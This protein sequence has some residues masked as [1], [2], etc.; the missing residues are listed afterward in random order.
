MLRIVAIAETNNGDNHPDCFTNGPNISNELAVINFL[1]TND[2]TLECQYAPIRFI[3]YDCGDNVLSSVT[4]DTLF[5]SRNIYDFSWGAQFPNWTNI[6][7]TAD[8]PTLF[9]AQ[10]VDCFVGDE[11]KIPFR[12][13]DF[14]NGGI[15][16]VCADSID[17]RGDV[18]LNEIPYEVA[19][20]VLFS[21]YFVY[22]LSA[23]HGNVDGQIAATDANADGIVL[24]VADLVYLIR[25]VIGDANP[26][27]KTVVPI[28]A[29]YVQLGN[30]V[31]SV[32][33]NVEMG[34]AFVVLEGNVAPELKAMNMEMSYNYDGSNTRVLVYSLEGNSFTGDFLQ[35]NVA[36]ISIEMA[37]ADG[38]PVV[39]KLLPT[40]F[41][42][43]QNYPNPFNPTTTLGFSLPYASRYDL[44]I[45]N[46][47]GQQVARFAG[48]AEAGNHTID[49]N[50]SNLASGVYLYKLTADGRQIDTKKMVLLK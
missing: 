44:T 25:V 21:N 4:G 33:D 46:V 50:A 11:N 38:S 16:I 31:L 18:N 23:F 29:S 5:I 49:W 7:M 45:Y 20:A 43:V 32:N 39:A 26:Y 36:I 27:P 41:A 10:D 35:F 37:T 3:W 40:E 19:D 22:G 30:G 12:R 8:Y 28:N 2:R 14:R 1:V 13:V 48:S 17:S 6:A 24:S 9:G 47:S 42:L 15:D 34:A